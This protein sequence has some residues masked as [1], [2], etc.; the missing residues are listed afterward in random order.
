MRKLILIIAIYHSPFSFGQVNLQTGAAQVNI[1]LF[2]YSDNNDLN[3]NIS[4]DYF[5]GNG[6]KVSEVA[7]S[8]G[9][10]WSLQ[11]GGVIT[12]EQ[13]GLPDDQ[14]RDPTLPIPLNMTFAEYYDKYFPNGY[15]FSSYSPTDVISNEGG[16]VRM[17]PCYPYGV[18]PLTSNGNIPIKE[19][20]AADRE[21]DIFHLDYGKGKAEFVIGKNGQ[22][23]VLND[24]RIKVQMFQNNLLG[25]NIKTW[26]S[27]FVV[28]DLQ[29]IQYIFSA[30]ELSQTCTYNKV[31]FPDQNFSIS[32][33]E[34]AP[35]GNWCAFYD[36][37]NPGYPEIPVYIGNKTQSY[38]VTKWYLTEILNTRT[39]KLITFNYAQ[40][41]I[42]IL[43]QRQMGCVVQANQSNKYSVTINREIIKALRLVNINYPT[44]KVN[45]IYETTPRIDVPNANP[46][47]EI[48][49]ITNNSLLKKYVFKY[50]YFFKSEVRPYNYQFIPN[51]S[52][53]ARLCLTSLQVVGSDGQTTIQ[54]YL[55]DY[56][57]GGDP[58]NINRGDVIPPTFSY[59]T[60]HWG[61]FNPQLQGAYQ[62]FYSPD[63]IP[64]GGVF[65]NICINASSYRMP[66]NG[67]AKNGIIKQITYP[68]GGTLNYEYEQND[69]FYNGQNIMVGGVRVN[70]TILFDGINHAKDVVKEYKYLKNDEVS[71]SGWGYELPVYSV[72]KDIRIYQEAGNKVGLLFLDI[73]IAGSTILRSAGTT[74]GEKL[75]TTFFSQKQ[76]ASLLTTII[77]IFQIIFT[78]TDPQY[79]DQTEIIYS[80]VSNQA[81]NPLPYQYSRIEEVN[82]TMAGDNGITVYEFTSDIDKPI[83]ILSFPFPFSNKDRFVSWAY[84]LPKRVAK[85]NNG[86]PR[87]ILKETINSYN[88]L[89]T[90]MSDANFMS[91]KWEANR[92]LYDAFPSNRVPFNYIGEYD[93]TESPIYFPQIG[94]TELS[95]TKE[96]T[97]NKNDNG[98]EEKLITYTYNPNNFQQKTIISTNSKQETIKQQIYYPEDYTSSGFIT[99]LIT[100]NM[101]NAP[102]CSEIWITKGA[103]QPQL[104]N[105]TAT[106]FSVIANGDIKPYK[107]YNLESASPVAQNILQPFNVNSVVRDANYIKQ[108]QQYVYDNSGNLIQTIA[109]AKPSSLLYDYNNSLVTLNIVNANPGEFAYTSFEAEN[110]GGWNYN[111]SNILSI[112]CPTGKKCFGLGPNNNLT[113]NISVS[114]SYILSFWAYDGSSVKVNGVFNPSK[115]GNTIS[116]FTYYEFSLPV[117]SSS[118]IISGTS[119]IDEVR[120][121]P[122]D[123]RMTT[124]TFDLLNNKTSECDINNRIIYYKYDALGRMT[125]VFDES[126][127][128][129]KAFEYNIKQ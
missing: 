42:D 14:K 31:R 56:F 102:L 48:Q 24:S 2:S 120:L 1:P 87:K 19:S 9:T 65:S 101:V 77:Q 12:R 27:Y 78:P 5:D 21:Q 51:E 7:S 75:T 109:K 69:A 122:K 82:K 68:F 32:L 44:G 107:T 34:N 33:N 113:T 36:G 100:N 108:Q 84:G 79:K 38:I 67:L 49:I 129:I 47:K 81:N 62:Y 50:S 53:F 117:G 110:Q 125:T 63:K 52:F 25:N 74:L 55:F 66:V 115:V 106:E 98:Y 15:L 16:Y 94:H 103:T 83:D 17:Y 72:S 73:G 99:T 20:I 89:A 97:Y 3:C 119:L 76:N 23:K 37:S 116:G 105:T 40:Y 45:F 121:F 104:I 118:P 41:D 123:S 18:N 126:Q 11:C 95:T 29:G 127:N 128:I 30:T 8:V 22:I 111:S 57:T 114:K 59:W 93:I 96:R 60:D 85:Y 88:F 13:R 112:T 64:L 35:A 70:K 92:L 80:N 86:N 91:K 28:T 71:S 90:F 58:A 54:P 4:L 39:N 46:L 61:F 124:F 10:G 43:G 6:L 26:I